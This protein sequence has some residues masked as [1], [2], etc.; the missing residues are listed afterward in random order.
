[1]SLKSQSLTP[2]QL[3]LLHDIKFHK[4][5]PQF[6][7]LL[8]LGFVKF[9]GIDVNHHSCHLFEPLIWLRKDGNESFKNTNFQKHTHVGSCAHTHVCVCVCVPAFGVIMRLKP[10]SQSMQLLHGC[11][12]MERNRSQIKSLRGSRPGLELFQ[13]WSHNRRSSC[14]N[15]LFSIAAR[16]HCV[17]L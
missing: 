9:I 5:C 6:Q 17:L 1:M 16:Q 15:P 7:A 2:V 13:L 4:L 3:T 10:W 8:E 11:L 12:L 14:S